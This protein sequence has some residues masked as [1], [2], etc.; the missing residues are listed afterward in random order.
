MGKSPHE[1]PETIPSDCKCLALTF[2]VL[3]IILVLR[4]MFYSLPVDSIRGIDVFVPRVVSWGDTI[5]RDTGVAPPPTKLD[6][7]AAAD[8]M[9]SAQSSYYAALR[10][11]RRPQRH[12]G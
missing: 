2:C 8:T 11:W 5:S 6:R 4:G 3:C 12:I 9:A 1:R 7:H 10:D